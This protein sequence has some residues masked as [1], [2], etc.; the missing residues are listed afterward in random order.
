VCVR[1]VRIGVR[2]CVFVCACVYRCVYAYSFVFVR[3]HVDIRANCAVVC[4]VASM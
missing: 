2:V 3:E 4:V 1:V